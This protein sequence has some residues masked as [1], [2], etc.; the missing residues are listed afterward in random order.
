MYTYLLNADGVNV[1]TPTWDLYCENWCRWSYVGDGWCNSVCYTEACNY[2][3]GDCDVYC[4]DGCHLD[5]VGN[6]ECDFSCM[7]TN[8][9][10]DN[11]DCDDFCYENCHGS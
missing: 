10:N 8:C 3:G 6:G 1:C 5:M 9:M 4:A 2:D 11:G 7:T